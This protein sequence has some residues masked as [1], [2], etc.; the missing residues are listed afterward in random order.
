MIPLFEKRMCSR[1]VY[2]G[3]P[4]GEFSAVREALEQ[5]R[6]RYRKKKRAKGRESILVSRRDEA[7]ARK[8]VQLQI[9]YLWRERMRKY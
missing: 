9:N 7:Q 3:F 4:S 2:S 5:G 6:I 1:E 8:L